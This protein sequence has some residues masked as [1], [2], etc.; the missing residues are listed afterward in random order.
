ML[1]VSPGNETLFVEQRRIMAAFRGLENIIEMAAHDRRGRLVHV[2]IDAFLA[3]MTSG[4]TSSMPC[5]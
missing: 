1:Q 5:V 2:K 4:R 3:M